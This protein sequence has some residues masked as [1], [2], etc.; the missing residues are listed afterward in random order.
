MASS[1]EGPGKKRKQPVIGHRRDQPLPASRQ[2]PRS[3]QQPSEFLTDSLIHSGISSPGPP[4][5]STRLAERA[6]ARQSFA[7]TRR[8]AAALKTNPHINDENQPPS[9]DFSPAHSR[10]HESLKP[11]PLQRT[12]SANPRSPSRVVSS[13]THRKTPS[14]P[15]GRRQESITS[16]AV[17][18]P[19]PGRGYAEAYQRIVDEEDLAQEESMEDLEENGESGIGQQGMSQGVERSRLN[20]RQHSQSPVSTI[21]SGR[22]SLRGAPEGRAPGP[23]DKIIYKQKMTHDSGSESGIEYNEDFTD[24]SVDSG[25]S[26]HARDLARL[27]KLTQSARAFGKPRVGAKVGLT[28]DNLHRRH[29]SNESLHSAFS[30]GNLSIGSDPSLS[31]TEAWDRKAKPGK[32]WLNRINS[33]SGRLTGDVSK[34]HS[35]GSQIIAESQNHER[36]APVDEWIA[37]AA[38]VHLPS[39]NEESS[40]SCVSPRDSTPTKAVQ[41]SGSLDQRRQWELQDDEFTGRTLQ[42]SE[43]PPLRVR[44]ATL[45]RIRDREIETLEKRALTTGRLHELRQSMPDKV[46]RPPESRLGEGP[47]QKENE[48]GTQDPERRRPSTVSEL[49][50]KLLEADKYGSP[51]L[52]LKAMGDPIA[53]TINAIDEDES[54]AIS[55]PDGDSSNVPT[56]ASSRPSHETKDPQDLL[57]RLARAL[58]KSPEPVKDHAEANHEPIEYPRE[59]NLTHALQVPRAPSNLETPRI[60][61]GWVENTAEQTPK[62]LQHQADL[63]TPRVTGAWIDTPLPTGGRGLPMPTPSDLDDTKEQPSTSKLAASDLIHRLNSNSKSI[64]PK[65]S[66]HTPLKY[67]GPA[68]PKSAL[69]EILKDAKSSI[70]SEE[71][72]TALRNSASEDEP[73]LL[74]GETTIRS[75][76]ELVAKDQ[77]SPTLLAPTPPS[78]EGTSSSTSDDPLPPSLALI[79]ASRNLSDIQSYTHLLSRLTNM[80]P[81]LYASSKKIASLEHA[82][83]AP[84]SSNGPRDLLDHNSNAHNTLDEPCPQCGC[85]G[86]RPDLGF[87]FLYNPK[88]GMFSLTIPFPRL[89]FWR[90]NDWR[91]R[92]TWLGLIV[93]LTWALVNAE[94]FARH[95]FCHQRYATHMIGYGVDINAPRPPFVLAKVLWRY[96]VVET[97]FFAVARVLVRVLGSL[98]GYFVGFITGVGNG[99]IGKEEVRAGEQTVYRGLDLGMIGD[100][101]L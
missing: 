5:D 67:S 82:V 37:R 16:P 15:R 8:L 90:R 60:T 68:L 55:I 89:W 3:L 11:R 92:L 41:R 94:S 6:R 99:G 36:E 59:E 42:V 96:A 10:L 77:D 50:P 63:K 87:P 95:R 17:S 30:S 51:E 34:R 33:R 27:S 101:Y 81:S 28:S 29:E 85:P 58:S 61:G 26:Q 79:R 75:L 9:P 19:S 2:A 45:D 44:N 57:R 24:T 13:P 91:P 56:K 80:A 43:S 64:R 100:E 69:A 12:S 22:A 52:P 18:E 66:S 46:S 74:L 71:L 4:K 49:Q 70:P 76:K 98:V 47:E 73:P 23:Q 65:L 78:E 32:D 62:D 21:A 35:S 83:S 39:G 93:I 88:T 72:P 1:F 97:P 31:I 20:G 86:P 14:P 84:P 40:K 38:E 7:E 48:N 53:D 25:L 54:H